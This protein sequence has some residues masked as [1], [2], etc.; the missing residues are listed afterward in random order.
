M[1]QEILE[2]K[3]KEIIDSAIRLYSLD[4]ARV[5]VIGVSLNDFA[6]KLEIFASNQWTE[7]LDFSG[8][9]FG[10]YWLHIIVEPA[11]SAINFHKILSKEL[12]FKNEVSVDEITGIADCGEQ[13]HKVP[14]FIFSEMTQDVL[15]HMANNKVLGKLADARV[16][17]LDN[18]SDKRLLIRT[19]EFPDASAHPLRETAENKTEIDLESLFKELDVWP[20]IESYKKMIHSDGALQEQLLALCVSGNSDAMYLARQCDDLDKKAYLEAFVSAGKAGC[21]NNE[22]VIYIRDYREHPDVDDLQRY[23]E[24]KPWFYKAAE[25]DADTVMYM[26]NLAEIHEKLKQDEKA[27]QW[28]KKAAVAGSTSAVVKN[29]LGDKQ[30]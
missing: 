25:A 4:A 8:R 27:E 16:H 19:L 6:T 12:C 22:L 14:V 17:L 26:N 29:I 20:N 24:A 18:S 23:E 13:L 15:L 9:S 28:A 1:M 2:K 3:F 10:A 21:I 30:V 5:R 7:Y 11:R